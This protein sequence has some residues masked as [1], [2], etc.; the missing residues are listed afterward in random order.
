MIGKH[1]NVGMYA[2]GAYNTRIQGIDND[3][4]TS[5]YRRAGEKRFF[6]GDTIACV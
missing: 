2:M 5:S 1:L 4:F 6:E 3:I